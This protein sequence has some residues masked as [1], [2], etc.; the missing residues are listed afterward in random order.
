MLFRSRPVV[1]RFLL[2]NQADLELRDTLGR[3][4]LHWAAM[5]G[6]KSMVE[7]LL[8]KGV[9]VNARIQSDNWVPSSGNTAL[10]LAADAGYRNEAALVL[11]QRLLEALA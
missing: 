2:D 9:D 10:H 6:H 7:L 1:A 5:N 3:T 4:P 11:L 8:S